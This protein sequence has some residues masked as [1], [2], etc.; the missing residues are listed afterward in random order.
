[1]RLRS[2][3]GRATIRGG[4]CCS[5]AT[6]GRAATTPASTSGFSSRRTTIF[7]RGGIRERPP[8]RKSS[9]PTS[10]GRA[11]AASASSNT[12]NALSISSSSKAFVL[13]N[14]SRFAML[15][16]QLEQAIEVGSQALQMAEELGLEELQAVALTKI[17]TA[18]AL[19]GDRSGLEEL[20]RSFEI[21]EA[22]N[23]HES[24]ATL[25]NLGS[26]HAEFGELERAW[27]L[28]QQSRKL[29][30]RFGVASDIRWER[31]ERA[32]NCYYRGLWDESLRYADDFIAESEAGS[33]HYLES[34]CRDVRGR[35]RLARGDVHGAREDAAKQLELARV[36]G[37]PQVL[38]SAIS[39]QAWTLADAGREREADGLVSELLALWSEGFLRGLSAAL[40]VAWT[41]R[42]LHREADLLELLDNDANLRLRV[43]ASRRVVSGNLLGAADLCAEIGSLPDDAYARL[44]SAE[45]FAHEGRRA[46]ADAQLKRALA[47]YGSV[48][49]AA[50]ARRAE[51]LLAPSA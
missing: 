45:I 17:G 2:S 23:S 4:R 19:M 44:R 6:A 32:A 22:I 28:H 13:A 37:E 1:M 10:G 25:V 26:M 15:A 33:P 51:V 9:S 34:I 41:V 12:W 21:A 40:D 36:A 38:A 24:W 48:G 18:R 46:D 14:A 16:G 5:F 3:F 42:A 49:A 43:E 30:D 35:I 50:Y 20:E 7:W 39:F 27:E 11:A 31:A 47:F 8:K 29:A